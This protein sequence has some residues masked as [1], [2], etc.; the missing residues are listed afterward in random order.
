MAAFEVWAQ[1]Y[2]NKNQSMLMALC[3]FSIYGEVNARDVTKS[4]TASNAYQS[5]CLAW[6]GYV[7]TPPI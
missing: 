4:G 1:Y 2:I 5:T 7:Q 3:A 6:V